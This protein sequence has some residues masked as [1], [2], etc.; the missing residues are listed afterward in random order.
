MQDYISKPLVFTQESTQKEIAN[1]LFNTEF[2]NT[3][4]MSLKK[5]K[6]IIKPYLNNVIVGEYSKKKPRKVCK[7]IIKLMEERDNTII[8]LNKENKQRKTVTT[9]SKP[10]I[11]FKRKLTKPY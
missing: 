3:E 9:K 11:K 1:Y 10:V 7:E 6:K 8:N 5:L 2:I 4:I